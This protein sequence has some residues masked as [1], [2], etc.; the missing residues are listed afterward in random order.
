MKF[1]ILAEGFL[2][3]I[4][5]SVFF[6]CAETEKNIVKNCQLFE[7]FYPPHLVPLEQE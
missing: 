3:Y 5:N 7:I 6:R 1:T 2:E 4:V